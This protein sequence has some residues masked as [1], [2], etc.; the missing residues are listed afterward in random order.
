VSQDEKTLT[1]MVKDT[2][3]AETVT[4]ETE[5]YRLEGPPAGSHNSSGTWKA[6]KTSRSWAVLSCGR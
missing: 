4:I 6:F 5:S 3:E 1:Q 2:T